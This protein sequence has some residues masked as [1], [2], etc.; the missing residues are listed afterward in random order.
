VSIGFGTW[1]LL[2]NLTDTR[3]IHLPLRLAYGKL[4][5]AYF[6]RAKAQRLFLSRI[7][8]Y[9]KKGLPLSFIL[10][11]E[12][13]RG[14]IMDILTSG[15]F[16]NIQPLDKGWSADKKYCA[17]GADGTKYLLR[18]SPAS[19]YGR[20]H[21]LFDILRKVAALGVHICHPIELDTCDEGVYTLHSWIDGPDLRET[22]PSLPES[23]QCKL[24]LQSGQFLKKIHSIPAPATK[25]DWAAH[26]NKKINKRIGAYLKCGLR[27]DGDEYI[28][29]FLEQ[30]RNL[31]IGR[32]W[33]F[34]HGDY[35]DGNMMLQHGELQII[36]F[37]RYDFED[38]WHDFNRISFSA[39]TSPIFASAQLHGYFNGEPPEEFFVL[40]ALYMASNTLASIPWAISFG[41]SEI[42]YMVK[43]SQDMLVWYNNMKNPVPIWYRES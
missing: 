2:Q 4:G 22:L 39:E 11:A 16:I 14:C 37:D 34:Q 23:N 7:T 3:R 43:R 17:T 33:S 27:F 21:A 13:C 41:Q 29:D 6:R 8:I 26:Y 5:E 24:G 31:L 9:D 36:D 12:K 40:L 15:R 18:I 30:N 42:D 35:H 25:S 38:P 19:Q 1:F 20:W 28:L 10:I 32:P